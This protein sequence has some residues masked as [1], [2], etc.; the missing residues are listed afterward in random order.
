MTHPHLE[1]KYLL[2]KVE[3][4]VC[5]Q[6]AAKEDI[7]WWQ[8]GALFQAEAAKLHQAKSEQKVE[9]SGAVLRLHSSNGT[10]VLWLLRDNFRGSS[11]KVSLSFKVQ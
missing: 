10:E 1:L 11:P 9:E 8:E 3:S 2:Y 6:Y 7:L 4:S 5:D